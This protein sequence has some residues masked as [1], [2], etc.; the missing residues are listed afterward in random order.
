MSLFSRKWYRKSNWEKVGG[1]IR[2]VAVKKLPGG[3]KYYKYLVVCV[4]EN[5]KNGEERKR[6]EGRYLGGHGDEWSTSP[7]IISDGCITDADTYN[8]VPYNG[9]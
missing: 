8:E 1:E 5:A 2:H 6:Y 9:D 3:R 7:S 4:Y